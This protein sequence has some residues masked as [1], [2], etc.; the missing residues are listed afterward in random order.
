MYGVKKTGKGS[1]AS[2]HIHYAPVLKGIYAKAER[3]CFDPYD[4]GMKVTLFISVIANH[5]DKAVD[6]IYEVFTVR[7]AEGVTYWIR[8]LHNGSYAVYLMW[9]IFGLALIIVFFLMW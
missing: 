2:D 9:S 5:L 4:I 8:Q 6:W 7:V 1:G 3:R